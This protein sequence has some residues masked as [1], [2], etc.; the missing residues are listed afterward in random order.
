LAHQLAILSD[1]VTADA[2]EIALFPDLA[3]RYQI[4]STPALVI[5]D[6][7]PSFGFLREDELM[8]QT[9]HIAGPRPF[10]PD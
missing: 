5:N 4:Y 1:H 9:L 10:E 6:S 2:V 3:Q 7:A 8:Q